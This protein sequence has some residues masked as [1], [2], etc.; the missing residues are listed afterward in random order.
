MIP[1]DTREASQPQG[2]LS[3][4][5]VSQTLGNRMVAVAT[6]CLSRPVP[7]GQPVCSRLTS[8]RVDT[9]VQL[10]Q[11]EIY[12]YSRVLSHVQPNFSITSS[13]LVYLTS[14]SL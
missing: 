13:C 1:R 4:E 9:G 11:G 6:S 2:D 8:G 7:Q 10:L 14:T 3:R 12:M 5:D